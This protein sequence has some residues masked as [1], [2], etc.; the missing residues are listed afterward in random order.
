[1]MGN[2]GSEMPMSPMGITVSTRTVKA[3]KVTFSVTN[4]S[5][6]ME[7]EMVVS[8]IKDENANLPYNNASQIVDEGAAGNL[9]EVEELD[10]GKRGSLTI[11]LK[12][13][14]YVLYCNIAGHYALGMWTLLTVK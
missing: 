6:V 10:P 9:G 14:N 3:G 5:E 7:H 4:S 11:E 8:P 12:P 1:M 2:H 13:G